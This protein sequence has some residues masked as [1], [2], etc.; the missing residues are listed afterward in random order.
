MT[1]YKPVILAIGGTDPTG[2]AGLAAD[3]RTI[4]ALGGHAAPVVSAVTV[5]NNSGVSAINPVPA[6]RLQAQLD[7]LD[8]TALAC[9]KI[10]LLAS[11]EQIEVVA[12]FLAR[13]SL[14]AVVDPVLG[15]TSGTVFSNESTRLALQNVLFPRARVVTPNLP[16]AQLLAD[17][18]SDDPYELAACLRRCVSTAFVIKGGHDHD[19]HLTRD[20]FVGPTQQFSLR[21]PRRHTLHTRGTGCVFASALATALAR[22][23]RLED[24]VVIAKMTINQ[25]LRLAY[26]PGGQTPGVPGV[27]A[28][29]DS[30]VDLPTLQNLTDK[31]PREPAFPSCGDT[32]LGLYPI[33]DRAA[34]LTRLLAQGVTTI[35]LR[36]K[37]LEGE[38]LNLEIQQAVRIARQH[39]CRLFI[40]DY[41]QAAVR[42]GAYGVH[43]GQEDLAS[44]DLD[45]IHSAGLR[46]GISTHCH[47]EVA[48]A[49]ACKPSY[50]ACGPVYP[51][52]SKQ[53]PWQ[54]LGIEGLSYWSKLLQPGYPVVAIAG[55][56][57]GNITK[58]AATGVSGI[59]LISA[60]SQAQD[61]EE[62]TRRLIHMLP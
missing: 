24:A 54:T 59:A 12:G 57:A 40:N 46:L 9:V 42:H 3:L 34:W 41:W 6:D 37:D 5:Q 39:D 22:G 52:T 8:P 43:L 48:R 2:L 28:W 49:L 38:A 58:V 51:T 25:G 53:M 16:E 26:A 11:T 62:S 18:P 33:V 30:L 50:I 4:T 7:A 31:Y 10:G 56:D 45:A 23:E 61:P 19:S 20:V 15:S 14:P 13:S 32:P 60:I 21:S 36:I 55:I 17:L 27:S 44:A 35:Q 1:Q 29:P 47:A